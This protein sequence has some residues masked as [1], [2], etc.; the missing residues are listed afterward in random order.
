MKIIKKSLRGDVFELVLKK[1]HVAP[2]YPW[3]KYPEYA[4][5]RHGDNNKWF[6]LV[7]NVARNKLGLAGDD[8]VN[9]L[10]VK[11]DSVVI[12]GFKRQPG[13][14]PAYHMNKSSWATILLDGSVP[15]SDIEFLLGVSYELTKKKRQKSQG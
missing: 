3:V 12:G 9:I 5:L 14:L 6:G 1:Y 2:D 7:G 13:I 10:N 11:V 8:I 15:M 4:I